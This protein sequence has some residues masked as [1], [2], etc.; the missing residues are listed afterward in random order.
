VRVA[1]A[2]ALIKLAW[3]QERVHFQGKYWQADNLPVLPQPVQQPHPPLLLA[4]NSNDTSPYGE[5]TV[6][7]SMACSIAL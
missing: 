1:E 6:S 3:T 4:A 2:I 7:G 5:Y